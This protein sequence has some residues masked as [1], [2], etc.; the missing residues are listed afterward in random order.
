MIAHHLGL[1]AVTLSPA[2][3]V[4]P[5]KAAEIVTVV[6]AVTRLVETVNVALVAPTATVT[7][8]GAVATAGLLLESVMTAP[9]VGAGLLRVTVPVAEDP[10]RTVVGLTLT[11]ERSGSGVTVSTADFVAPPKVAEIVTAVDDVTP[12][13]E[14]GNWLLVA[15]AAT[16]TVAGIVTTLVSLLESATTAPPGGAHSRRI[17]VPVAVPPPITLEGM[18]ATDESGDRV[19][20]R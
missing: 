17:T 20:S 5:S 18:R 2:D 10:P 8:S 12:V 13:V 11:D 16:V 9:P 19:T 15:P 7:L 4:T 6:E 1:P 3:L 14:T